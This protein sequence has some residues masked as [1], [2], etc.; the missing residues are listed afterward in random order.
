MSFLVM[1]K[2]LL[3]L[4]VYVNTDVFQRRAAVITGNSSSPQGSLLGS[5]S[6]DREAISTKESVQNTQRSVQ[7][8][9][10]IE[11]PQAFS[12]N[13]SLFDRTRLLQDEYPH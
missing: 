11:Q 13:A 7:N 2:H 10:A 4:D 9:R 1:P 6:T 5:L 8:E 3:E 12:P